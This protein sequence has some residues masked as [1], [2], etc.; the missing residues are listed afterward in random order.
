[1]L[2]ALLESWWI[3]P[4]L[5]A[6]LYISDNLLTVACARIYHGQD[7]IVFEGSYEITPFYQADVNAQRRLSLRF[8]IA[9]LGITGYLIL[10]QTLAGEA[11]VF[12]YLYAGALGALIL[13]QVT[14]HVRHLRNWF[15]FK[16]GLALIQGRLVY[17]RQLLLRMSAFELILFSG[18]YL[19]LAVL[20]E[21]LFVLGGSLGCGVLAV[22]HY[23]LARQH[24]AS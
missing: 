4:A 21:S 5:W 12:A 16:N 3:G 2:D 19:V 15:L 14:I 7:T 23:Q 11:P 17:A 20:T 13:I 8:W 10:V 9:L 6:A 18:V 1:M 24:P 22:S